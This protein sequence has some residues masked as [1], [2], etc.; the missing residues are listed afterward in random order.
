[1]D[2]SS[3]EAAKALEAVE[4]SKLAMRRAIMNSRGPAQLW[5]WGIAW[6]AMAV[7]RGLNHPRFWVAILWVSVAGMIVSVAVGIFQSGRFRAKVDKRFMGV[8]ATLLIFGYGI[9]PRFFA[10]YRNYDTAYAYQVILWM[11]LYIVGGIWF[12]TFLLW[13]GLLITAIIMTGFLFFPGLFWLSAFLS[14]VVLFCSGFYIQKC[15]R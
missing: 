3:E 9:W 15:W 13:V 2:I 14:G 11:Q 8:C 10:L 5:I 7:I 1:M 4:S 6:M 12:D